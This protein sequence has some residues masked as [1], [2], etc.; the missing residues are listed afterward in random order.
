MA[1]FEQLWPILSLTLQVCGVAVLIS[2]VIGLPIGVWMGLNSFRGKRFVLGITQT[3]MA[4]PPVVVGL[5]LYLLL[6][7]SGPL[8]S[9]GWLFSPQAMI[10]RRSFWIFLLLS[11]S[12]SLRSGLTRE[13]Q[14]QLRSLGASTNQAGWEIV[15]ESRAGILLAVATALREKPFRSRGGVARRREYPRPHARADDR[16]R[17]GNGQRELCTG[18]VVGGHSLVCGFRHQLVYHASSM[19]DAAM[20]PPLVYELQAIRKKHGESFALQI[21]DLTVYDGETLCV[22]GPTGAGKTTFLRLLSGL[23]APTSGRLL[24][25]RRHDSKR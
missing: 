3:G 23:D 2:A 17:L 7:R 11:A 13:L 14:W 15:C 10:L 6:S 22:V 24:W 5:V 1:S 16:N 8:G 12:L 4:L 20:M 18:L 9:L 21:D 19:A 25:R